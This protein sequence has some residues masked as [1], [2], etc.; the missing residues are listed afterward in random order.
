VL[1]IF[2]SQRWRF[3][4]FKK[5]LLYEKAG[6]LEVKISASDTRDSHLRAKHAIVNE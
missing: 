4:L 6:A 2:A 3:V 5:H 1:D